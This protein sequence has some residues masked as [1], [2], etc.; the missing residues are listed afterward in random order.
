MLKS[1]HSKELPPVM[2]VDPET[3]VL[4]PAIKSAIVSMIPG[5]RS[6][7]RISL[8]N[9]TACLSAYDIYHGGTKQVQRCEFALNIANSAL[10]QIAMACQL[11]SQSD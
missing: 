7:V 5:T 9:I 8:E 6:F 4:Q 11:K 3:A 1:L 2:T 10:M